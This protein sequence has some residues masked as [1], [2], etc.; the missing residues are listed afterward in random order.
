M[1]DGRRSLGTVPL[2]MVGTLGAAVVALGYYIQINGA[3][4]MNHALR[5][6]EPIGD[7]QGVPLLRS[8]AKGRRIALAICEPHLDLPRLHC[9]AVQMPM[10]HEATS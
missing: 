1:A 2:W 9:H 4:T 8:N 7:P 5:R 3:S 6:K 10:G